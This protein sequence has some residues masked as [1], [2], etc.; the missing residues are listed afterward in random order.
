MLWCVSY[1]VI[2]GTSSTGLSLSPRANA[3]RAQA[4]QLMMNI[5]DALAEV[6]NDLPVET[7]EMPLLQ[8]AG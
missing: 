4:A 1:G 2:N 6:F 8:M 3:T 5:S 7:Q